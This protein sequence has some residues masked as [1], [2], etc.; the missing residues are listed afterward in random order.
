MKAIRPVCLDLECGPLPEDRY[1]LMVTNMVMHH[2]ADTLEMLR[3]DGQE[4]EAIRN[5]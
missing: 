1:D 4:A 2:V 3:K 5:C